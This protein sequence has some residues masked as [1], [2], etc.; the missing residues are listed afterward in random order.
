[1][2]WFYVLLLSAFASAFLL[3]HGILQYFCTWRTSFNQNDADRFEAREIVMLYGG[4]S[5]YRRLMT[6]NIVLGFTL[7]TAAVYLLVR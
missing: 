1:M 6:R 5:R 2:D 3:T 4:I 7:L